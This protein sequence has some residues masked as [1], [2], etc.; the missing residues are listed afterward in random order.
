MPRQPERMRNAT[1]VAR[2]SERELAVTRVFD[3]PVGAVFE[4]WTRAELFRQW[5]APRSMG[6]AIGACEI[7]ARTGGGYRIVFGDGGQT[8]DFTYVA[9]AVAANL[10]ALRADGPL[11]GQVF[12]VGTGRRISLLDLVAAINE[13]LGTQVEPDFRPARAGD[14]RD[15]QA[16]LERIKAALNYV[17]LVD[18]EEGLRRTIQNVAL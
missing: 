11:K 2:R 6:A 3:S 14:V 7:D 1:T 4:P 15:S 10:A 16:S 12:N 5:W 17:P 9:N 8:R 13:I 18:F